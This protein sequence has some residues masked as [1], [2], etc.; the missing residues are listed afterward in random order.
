MALPAA[1]SSL[2]DPAFLQR[3]PTHAD[4]T[5]DTQGSLPSSLRLP[6]P[7]PWS[8]LSWFLL[9]LSPKDVFPQALQGW[10]WKL[11]LHLNLNSHAICFGEGNGTPLQYS[12]LENPMDGG[13]WWATVHGVAKSRTRLKRL[14]SSSY[15]F[16]EGV[17]QF[18]VV[19]QSLSRV[20]LC[21]PMDCRT[22]GF[23]ILHYLLEFVQTHVHLVDDAILRSYPL[24]PP[25][26][27]ALN[28]SQ[29]QGLFQWVNSPYQV[30]KVLE[31]R[32]QHQSFQCIFRV[33]FL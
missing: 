5:Q 22:P 14:S 17:T 24:S 27:L 29:H 10:F 30:A 6:T 16:K 33:D 28:L 23:P 11:S 1:P 21:D 31:L 18:V 4:K 26:V 20:W 25:S 12:C 7:H 19:V 2:L 8:F 9:S 13:A 32:L 3:L 15:L